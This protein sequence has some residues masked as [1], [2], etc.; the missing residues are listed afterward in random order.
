LPPVQ[1]DALL[2][3]AFYQVD[4]T[5]PSTNGQQILGGSTWNFQMWHRDASGGQVTSNTSDALQISF[6]D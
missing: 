4:F 5:S 2:G 6:G 3:I 1:A